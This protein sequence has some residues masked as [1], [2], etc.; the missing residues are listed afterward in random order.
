MIFSW[1]RANLSC[2]SLKKELLDIKR[3]KNRQKHTKIWFFWAICSFVA[4]N[5]ITSESLTSLFFKEQQEQFAHVALLSDFEKKSEEWKSERANSQPGFK[6]EEGDTQLE[7]EKGDGSYTTPD[8]RKARQWLLWVASRSN[9]CL[10]VLYRIFREVSWETVL[11]R[12]M[13]W[14]SAAQSP[15]TSEI[16]RR[17]TMRNIC[18]KASKRW[19]IRTEIFA[20][21]RE[22]WKWKS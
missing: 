3:G 9:L 1:K 11:P 10:S 17:A 13:W 5:S 21:Q 4:T 15:S 18:L 12:A 2:C 14:P 22:L 8:R 7:P 19:A 6:G 16:S 20:R